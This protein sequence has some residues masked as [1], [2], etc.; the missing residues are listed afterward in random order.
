M[1]SV[2]TTPQSVTLA[3]HVRSL[4]AQGRFVL[5][6]T[7]TTFWQGTEMRSLTLRPEFAFDVPSRREIRKALWRARSPVATYVCRPDAGHPQNAWLYVCC[8]QQYRLGKL[9]AAV[10]TNIRRALR[11][12]RFEFI[13][14]ETLLEHGVK[15]FC[16]TRSRVGLDDGTLAAYREMYAAFT[17]NPGRAVL[18]AWADDKLAAFTTLQLVDDWVD[19]YSY[20]DK[21]YLHLRPVN[22]LI[23]F[24][25][26]YFL[27]QQKYRLVSAGLSSIQEA[28]GAQGLHFFKRKVGFECWPVHRGTVFHPL[29]APA[30]NAGTLAVLRL[31][32]RLR[33]GSPTIRKAAG[34]L[35][36]HLGNN[37]M[38]EIN[39]VPPPREPVRQEEET[40]AF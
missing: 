31:L 20:A 24:V 36:S 34:L 9:D 17:S 40:A 12:L 6:A 16:D 39:A 30:A 38:P 33:P 11:C 1:E 4:V 7:P 37:P 15:P 18:G 8:D 2:L 10:R 27:V 19:I 21:D 14:D 29:L 26:D 23:H 13:S 3:E 5:P 35:A 22:G 32:R 28:S 25:F